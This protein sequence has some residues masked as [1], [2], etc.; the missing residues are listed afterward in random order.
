MNGYVAVRLQEKSRYLSELF[1]LLGFSG[2][3]LGCEILPLQ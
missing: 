2:S 3:R 1:L